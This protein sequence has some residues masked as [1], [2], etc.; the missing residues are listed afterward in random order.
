MRILALDIGEKRV[1]LA[2]SDSSEKLASPLKILPAEDIKAC[3][4]NFRSI[5]EDWEV[6][7][8]LVGLPL[9][10]SGESGKQVEAIKKIAANLQQQFPQIPMEFY[11]E[12]LSSKE[13]KQK[14][15]T[16]GLSEKDM[17]DKL[18]ALA[19]SIF[20]QAYLESSS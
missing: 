14:L 13:A 4:K 10:M 16:E 3:S 7:K 5:V 12:R 15:K 11:D 9:S 1:G 17:R 20:L 19:A 18:D 6:E 8:F 2:I